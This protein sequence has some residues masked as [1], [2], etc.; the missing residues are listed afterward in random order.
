VTRTTART[1]AALATV[2][3]LSLGACSADEPERP[4]TMPD[5]TLAGF[6]GGEAVDLGELRGPALVNLWASWCGPC[7]EEM[8]LLEEFHQ[9]HGDEVSVL[10]IDYQDAQP[11]KAAELVAQTGVTY[12]LV[13]DPDGEVSG[14]GAFPNL[15]GLPFW[16]LV[17]AD[18]MVTHLK[19]GEVDTVDEIVALAEQHL[20][21]TL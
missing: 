15:R 9:Q 6:D 2:L 11:A 16:A 19:A 5:V 14:Q 1:A 4:T 17:D 20:G 12:Q 8:P 10:G 13:T 3:A 21:V 18:G 7:R